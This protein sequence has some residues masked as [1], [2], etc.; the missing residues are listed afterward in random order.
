ML[1]EKFTMAP[2]SP[3]PFVVS[4]LAVMLPGQATEQVAGAELAARISTLTVEE[5]L[6]GRGSSVSLSMSTLVLTSVLGAPE[7]T[8]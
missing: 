7:L 5:L 8:V 1:P 2:G 6:A 4:A 3:L